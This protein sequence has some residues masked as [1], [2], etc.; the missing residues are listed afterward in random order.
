[1]GCQGSRVAVLPPAGAALIQLRAE[2]ERKE[3]ALRGMAM[4]VFHRALKNSEFATT[5]GASCCCCCTWWSELAIVA[6]VIDTRV[7]LYCRSSWALEC[8]RRYFTASGYS[9]QVLNAPPRTYNLFVTSAVCVDV[10]VPMGVPVVAVPVA[11][12]AV[13]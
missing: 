7:Y 12:A 11:A 2:T 6:H 4:D 13:A 5:T 10:G 3:R 1:M 8:V 9:A